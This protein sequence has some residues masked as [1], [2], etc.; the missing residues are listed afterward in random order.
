MGTAETRPGCHCTMLTST[1]TRRWETARATCKVPC[2]FTSITPSK[3]VPG[4]W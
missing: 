2:H 4:A 3:L 1:C